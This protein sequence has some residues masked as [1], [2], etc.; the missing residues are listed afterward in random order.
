[1]RAG[2]DGFVND[3][4]TDEMLA[5][6]LKLKDNKERLVLSL[7]LS[8]EA[9]LFWAA[10]IDRRLECLE[11]GAI[12]TTN[13]VELCRIAIEIEPTCAN[14]E[15]ESTYTG[16][17]RKDQ[18]EGHGTQTYAHGHPPAQRVGPF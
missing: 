15:R 5:R 14:G 1:M 6:W 4:A 7:C 13:V 18:R 11:H 17:W 12:V 8:E 16:D 2:C 10:D 3:A 9:H